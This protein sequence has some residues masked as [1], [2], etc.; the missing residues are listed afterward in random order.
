LKE[1]AYDL[2]S[3]DVVSEA[4]TRISTAVANY[5]PYISLQTMET[6]IIRSEDGN[7][8]LNKIKIIYSVNSIGAFDQNVEA[9]IVVTS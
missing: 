1:L 4:L 3:E 8:V 2:T 5:M 6:E 9:V 7:S